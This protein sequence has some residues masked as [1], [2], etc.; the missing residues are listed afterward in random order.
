[1]GEKTK[2]TICP[3]LDTPKALLSYLIPRLP[4]E[5]KVKNTNVSL[6]NSFFFLP[7]KTVVGDSSLNKIIFIVT[8]CN[9]LAISLL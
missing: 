1:M 8:A 2:P 6:K 7:L 3:S 4:T 5:M 9:Q